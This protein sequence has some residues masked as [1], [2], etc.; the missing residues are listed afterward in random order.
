[1]AILMALSK[2]HHGELNRCDTT[3]AR[4]TELRRQYANDHVALQQIDVYDPQSP[5]RPLLL[6]FRDALKLGDTKRMEKARQ[7]LK[8]RYPDV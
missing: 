4:Y 5:Y 3:R 6:E 2:K 1:M 7:Q 8:T